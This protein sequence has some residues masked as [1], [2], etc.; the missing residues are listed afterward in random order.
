M[1]KLI[2]SSFTVLLSF[3]AFVQG[4]FHNDTQV[5][6]YWGQASEGEPQNKL[7][8]YCESESLDIVVLAFVSEFGKNY[9]NLKEYEGLDDDDQYKAMHG[10]KQDD[11]DS[12]ILNLSSY[13]SFSNVADSY[14]CPSLVQDIKTCQKLGKK[15]LISF[16]GE[17]VPGTKQTYGFTDEEEGERFAGVLWNTFG[18]GN[19]DGSQ[20]PFDDAVI[21]GFDIDIENED[22]VGYVSMIREL[23]RLAKEKGTKRYY[24]SSA[25]QCN[26]PDKSNSELIDNF[27]LDYVFV[28]FYNNDCELNKD[29]VFNFEEWSDHITELGYDKTQI[30]VG[31]PSSLEAAAMGFISDQSL[32]VSKINEIENNENLSKHFGGL[33]FWDASKGY[34]SDDR[35][36][37]DKSYIF[38]VWSKLTSEGNSDADQS[39]L[40][41]NSTTEGLRGGFGSPAEDSGA[42]QDTSSNGSKPSPHFNTSNS[43]SDRSRSGGVALFDTNRIPEVL[44]GVTF[45]LIA[46]VFYC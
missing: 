28:Q 14:K 37:P 44:T 17:Y 46:F 8:Y 5:A 39:V 6:V 31:L 32:V 10:D 1:L 13:C 36:S 23:D 41:G 12:F 22:Q 30:F 43:G 40:D 2:T 35:D 18:E 11:D 27:E 20:R 34:H 26:F 19:V 9:A 33:M 25:P 3:I 45:V 21:D 24:F 7:S 4:K 16:G 38:N 29:D 15:V 42:T